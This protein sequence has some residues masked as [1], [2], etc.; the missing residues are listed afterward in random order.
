MDFI[1]ANYKGPAY[2]D[3]FHIA[4][5]FASLCLPLES[6]FLLSKIHFFG[7][8]F[9]QHKDSY[10]LSLEAIINSPEL[11][12]KTCVA[13]WIIAW[14]GFRWFRISRNLDCDLSDNPQ[15]IGS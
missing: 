11:C 12:S 2:P 13:P 9:H 7:F 1:T 15:Y 4:S 5:Q 6:P 10:D 3:D 8:K 14:L